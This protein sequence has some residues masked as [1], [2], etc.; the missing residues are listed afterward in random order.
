ML[1]WG[2]PDPT[3]ANWFDYCILQH[4]VMQDYLASIEK[5]ADNSPEKNADE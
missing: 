1:L 2:I 4:P 5:P 3:F